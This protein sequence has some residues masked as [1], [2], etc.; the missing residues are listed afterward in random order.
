MS[1]FK[2]TIS[3]FVIAF[4]ISGCSLKSGLYSPDFNTVNELKDSN[5]KPIN[6]EYCTYA[7]QS[8]DNIGLR[9]SSM[10]S[11]YGG[12]FADYIQKSLE[13]QLKSA[14][15]YDK[16]SDF[17]LSAVLLKN[18]LDANGFS[19]GTADISAKFIVNKNKVT[20]YE[21]IHSIHHEWDSSFLGNIAI[22][23]ALRNYPIAVQKLI[24]SLM[25]DKEFIKAVQENK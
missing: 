12:T 14:S 2:Y 15:L 13:E 19:T 8:I 9:G 24:N 10:V 22:P 3:F 17:S 6:V 20:Q 23:E 1:F 11:P 7:N 5:I 18:E 21:K 25:L 4:F 16:K